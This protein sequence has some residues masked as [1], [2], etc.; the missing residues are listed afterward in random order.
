VSQVDLA[1][2]VVRAGGIKIGSDQWRAAQRGEDAALP[3]QFA[4]DCPADG[5]SKARGGGVVLRKPL[6]Q[7]T[8][9]VAIGIQAENLKSRHTALGQSAPIGPK[10]ALL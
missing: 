5:G 3:R 6:G 4:S 10:R 1:A 8:D 2:V 9:Q 7:G